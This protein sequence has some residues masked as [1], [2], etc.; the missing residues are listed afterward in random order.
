MLTACQL[1]KEG[2]GRGETVG[3]AWP[4]SCS[5]PPGG[6]MQAVLLSKVLAELGDQEGP[7]GLRAAA[8]HIARGKDKPDVKL[9]GDGETQDMRHQDLSKSQCWFYMRGCDA[10]MWAFTKKKQH[11]PCL[12]FGVLVPCHVC[13]CTTYK[14]QPHPYPHACAVPLLSRHVLCPYLQLADLFIGPQSAPQ[15]CP[16]YA[17]ACLSSAFVLSSPA[18]GRPLH[19]PPVSAPAGQTALPG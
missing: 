15:L 1:S 18:A 8:V 6:A 12:Q 4:D 3:H 13:S 5:V 19:R 10:C 14:S 11:I 9:M 16:C 17:P 7:T 2:G